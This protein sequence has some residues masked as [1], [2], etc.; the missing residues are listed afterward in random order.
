MFS[1][2]REQ[3]N[4]LFVYFV[5]GDKILMLLRILRVR[6]LDTRGIYAKKEA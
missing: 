5:A 2:I 1:Y 4:H 3:V 6:G